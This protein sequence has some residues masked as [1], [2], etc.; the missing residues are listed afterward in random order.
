MIRTIALPLLLCAAVAPA[1]LAFHH[2]LSPEDVRNAYFI[3]RDPNRQ[4][5]FFSKYLHTPQLPDTGPDVACIEFR[6]PYEQIA[7]RS[8][9]SNLSNYFPPD[10]Q[11]DYET[12]PREVIV[13][14]LI[15]ATQTF[16]FPARDES[17]QQPY[18]GGF[19]FHVSQQ[20]R[21]IRYA[22]ATLEDALSIGGGSEGSGGFGGTASISTCTSMPPNSSPMIPSPSK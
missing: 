20:N 22:K 16:D 15:Y 2:H 12:H 10:A 9:D 14:V 1:A 21:S 18:L 4:D 11:Q 13:R 19:Q 17:S 6:T 3:G 8:R 5:A 7:I